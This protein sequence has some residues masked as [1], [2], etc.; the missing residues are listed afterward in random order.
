MGPQLLI[1]G[2]APSVIS[3]PARDR[4]IWN[5]EQALIWQGR[6]PTPLARQITKGV[7]R[8][9][10]KRVRGKSSMAGEIFHEDRLLI[11]DVFGEVAAIA[12]SQGVSIMG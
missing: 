12:I 1:D 7:H 3:T 4:L 9:P 6:Y 11:D 2:N 8:R 10:S 5:L